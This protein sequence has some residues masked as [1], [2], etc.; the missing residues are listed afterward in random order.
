MRVGPHALTTNSVNASPRRVTDL[1]FTTVP[2]G[3]RG[4]TG[5]IRAAIRITD[6]KAVMS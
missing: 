1:V 2:Y 5:P 6:G 3:M 4:Q